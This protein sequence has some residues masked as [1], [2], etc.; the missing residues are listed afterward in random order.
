[1]DKRAK[2]TTYRSVSCI[3]NKALWITV[4]I[5]DGPRIGGCA[6]AVSNPAS[7]GEPGQATLYIGA[8]HRLL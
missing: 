6:R 5:G 4:D 3:F 7:G 1:M 8:L 2:V